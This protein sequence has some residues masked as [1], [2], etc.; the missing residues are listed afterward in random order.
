LPA[1]VSLACIINE[2][3]LLENEEKFTGI[4]IFR[5]LRRQVSAPVLCCHGLEFLESKTIEAKAQQREHVK[6]PV[7]AGAGG[8][9]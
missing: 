4:E 7:G 2:I 3:S 6:P 1:I 5:F 9:A 8:R